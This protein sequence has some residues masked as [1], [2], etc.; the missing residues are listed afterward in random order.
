M[1]AISTPSAWPLGVP[2][3][4]VRPVTRKSSPAPQDPSASTTAVPPVTFK[5]TTLR[6]PVLEGAVARTRTEEDPD[7][8]PRD[9][10]ALSSAGFNNSTRMPE[11]AMR[12]TASSE[13]EDPATVPVAFSV[14]TLSAEPSSR[15]VS[16]NVPEAPTCPAGM[17]TSKVAVSVQAS[18]VAV[19]HE[20]ARV[21]ASVSPAA[22]ATLIVVAAV[23]SE[24]AA[25]ANPAVTVIV[26][27]AACS[28]TV[29]GET[30]TSKLSSLAAIVNVSGVTAP[31]GTVPVIKN[32]SAPSV[33]A[34]SVTAN[35]ASAVHAP[36]VCEPTGIDTAAG[37][38]GAVKSTPPPAADAGDAS[39]AVTDT[40][41]GWL[42]S[43][44]VA[45]V[46]AARTR[47]A[48]VSPSDNPFCSPFIPLS[49]SAVNVTPRSSST[50]PN[51]APSTANP[52]VVPPTSTDSSPSAIVS[53]VIVN[54]DNAT[55][56]PEVIPAGMLT[57]TALAGAVKSAAS[58]V[59][60]AEND[61]T[62]S[63]SAVNSEDDAPANPA[64]TDTAPA[65]PAPSPTSPSLSKVRVTASVISRSAP[66]NDHS[67]G[68]E[69]PNRILS[70]PSTTPSD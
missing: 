48:G 23:S 55:A 39:P 50:I 1:A 70:G 38:G 2:D 54:P 12:K 67:D 35:P 66:T 37:D 42:R 3:G 7:P 58:V 22:T 19:G 63:V 46:K 62:T 15:A 45:D 64:V 57:V 36:M 6:L 20:A 65:L 28:T 32:V 21:A 30:E 59:S 60:P 41:K 10:N 52:A 43:L 4:A 27:A 44:D 24:L 47:T 29:P 69:P 18:I 13:T 61:N 68:A 25:P 31:P 14:S 16:V 53:W 49:V 33:T 40:T 11:S 9:D 26:C 51:F 34:S 5:P 56:E 8:S 17:L